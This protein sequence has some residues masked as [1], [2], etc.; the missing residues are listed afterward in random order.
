VAVDLA[1]TRR[2]I[3]PPVMPF[4]YFAGAPQDTEVLF[5]MYTHVLICV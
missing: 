1:F 3:D 5:Q 4:R 2:R